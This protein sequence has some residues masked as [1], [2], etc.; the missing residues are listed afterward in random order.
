MLF[1]FGTFTSVQSL[2][3]QP[4]VRVYE[5]GVHISQYA[6][7][8]AGKDGWYVAPFFPFRQSVLPEIG[9]LMVRDFPD[10]AQ[11]GV[12]LEVSGTLGFSDD[13]PTLTI[14]KFRDVTAEIMAKRAAWSAECHHW[15]DEHKAAFAESAQ[16]SGNKV[17]R[18][19]SISDPV[20]LSTDPD[21]SDPLGKISGPCPTCGDAFLPL[22]QLLGQWFSVHQCG[23]TAGGASIMRPEQKEHE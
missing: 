22:G 21:P 23:L 9:A 12:Y 20:Y 4:C 14:R 18:T 7:R 1:P 6:R 5:P 15:Q 10:M 16:A 2:G 17:Y 11:R 19:Q 3:K 8:P 13:M